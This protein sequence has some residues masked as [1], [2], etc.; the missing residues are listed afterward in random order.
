MIKEFYNKIINLIIIVS[1]LLALCVAV[2]Y[3]T[4]IKNNDVSDNVS[5]NSTDELLGVNPNESNLVVSSK[6]KVYT[7]KTVKE[8][9]VPTISMWAKPSVRSGYSYTWYKF[10][11]IDYC[12]N[13]KHYNCLLK[14]PKGVPEME[15]TCKYC[16]SD[17]CAV[18]GKEK[19]S[20]SY[21]YLRRA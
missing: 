12:P 1:L 10:T 4:V 20:W 8:K 18:T 2:D 7:D 14:N 13:C 9:S 19:F 5:I 21:V 11:W 3:A 15:Y 6:D 16:D 17:F